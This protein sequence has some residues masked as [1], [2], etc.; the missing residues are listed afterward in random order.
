MLGI[1]ITE[2][3]SEKDIKCSQGFD[4]IVNIRV[5]VARFTIV[6]IHEYIGSRIIYSFHTTGA[7]EGPQSPKAPQFIAK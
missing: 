4:L 7:V 5:A 3:R 1:S 2:A 6:L